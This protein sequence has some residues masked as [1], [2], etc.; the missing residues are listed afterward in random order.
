MRLFDDRFEILERLG[1]GAMATVE[2]ARDERTDDLVALKRL[3][4]GGGWSGI[5]RGMLERESIVL[6]ELSETRGVPR[7]IASG[8]VEDRPYFAM[9]Y[10]EGEC[11]ADRVGAGGLDWVEATVLAGQAALRV[12]EIHRAGYVHRDLKPSN[13]LLDPRG[14]IWILDFGIAVRANSPSTPEEE[15]FVLGTPA[16]IAPERIGSVADGRDPRGDLYSLGVVLYELVTGRLPFDGPTPTQILSRA[17]RLEAP[18]IREMVPRAPRALSDAARRAM[19]KR[20]H[21]R[22]ATAGEFASALFGILNA[23]GIVG[24]AAA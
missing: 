24:S 11:L 18:P 3:P 8:E 15:E 19:A 14:R 2:L 10:L 1:E 17:E 4:A 13:L 21:D 22:F 20:P 23:E 6:R 12:D 9:E 16:F 7:L 5:E